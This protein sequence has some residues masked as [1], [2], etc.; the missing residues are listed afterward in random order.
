MYILGVKMS[1]WM[2]IV[3]GIIA[4]LVIVGIILVLIVWKKIKESG[5]KEPD[6]QVKNR[7]PSPKL[8]LDL[9]NLDK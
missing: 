1:E 3:L 7:S 6:F 9:M 8:Y 4:V 2:L 5:Y